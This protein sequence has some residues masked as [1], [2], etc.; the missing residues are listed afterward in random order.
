[1]QTDKNATTSSATASQHPRRAR[2]MGR[3]LSGD[4]RAREQGDLHA[5]YKA[6][7]P[8]PPHGSNQHHGTSEPCPCHVTP[9]GSSWLAE[10]IRVSQDVINTG[11]YPS[12]GPGAI[13][14]AQGWQRDSYP[15]SSQS[16]QDISRESRH[17]SDLNTYIPYSG[18][19][20][21]QLI[22]PHPLEACTTF[23]HGVWVKHTKTFLDLKFAVCQ[24]S[25]IQH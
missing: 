21:N 4:S 9:N 18:F 11:G 10:L 7:D 13:S 8:G 12:T 2:A 23:I 19:N 25:Q 22:T 20:S 3:A 17:F 14:G 1:M 5:I 15:C 24:R 16:Q 6:W